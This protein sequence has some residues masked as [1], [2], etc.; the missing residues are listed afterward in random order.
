M[1]HELTDAGAL[2]KVED[3]LRRIYAAEE[4]EDDAW[5]LHE[6]SGPTSPPAA[7]KSGATVARRPRNVSEEAAA[8]SEAS[9]RHVVGS[10]V[11][12]QLSDL[13]QDLCN[14]AADLKRQL[15]DCQA[16][17]LPLAV[18]WVGSCPS[19]TEGAGGDKP[20]A[21]EDGAAAAALVSELRAAAEQAGAA[22]LLA[23]P[24]LT[25]GP[26]L[27]VADVAASAAN[28]ALAAALKVRR[29]PAPRRCVFLNP[30]CSPCTSILTVVLARTES[31]FS[32]RLFCAI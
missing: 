17:G 27:L 11:R 26:L 3:E 14:G 12:I 21:V 1:V 7:A 29:D 24:S 31:T 23:C 5:R 18:A 8:A 19:P 13:V 9:D 16:R 2:D 28:A 6:E 32:F 20:A 10:A 4:P 15:R 30:M 25:L 22:L